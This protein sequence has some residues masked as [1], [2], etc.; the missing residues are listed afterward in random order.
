M[1]VAMQ[2]VGSWDRSFGGSQNLSSALARSCAENKLAYNFMSFNTSYTDTGLWG[3]YASTPH[4]KIEDFTYD[5][6]QEWL[7]ITHVGRAVRGGG[8]GLACD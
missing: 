3:V 5:L 6:T 1:I 2:I 4:D 8:K 7:R